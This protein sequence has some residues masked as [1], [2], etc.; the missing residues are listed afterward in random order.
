MKVCVFVCVSGGSG[1][2]TGLILFKVLLFFY[3]FFFFFPFPLPQLTAMLQ[4]DLVKDKPR[5]N[6]IQY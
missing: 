3:S 1:E 2:V 4:R 5:W 6:S